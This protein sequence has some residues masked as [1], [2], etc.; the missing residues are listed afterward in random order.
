MFNFPRW[1]NWARSRTVRRSGRPASPGAALPG[2]VAE[3][4]ELSHTTERDFLAVGAR[5]LEFLQCARRIASEMTEMAG[6]IS[7]EEGEH[8]LAA[9]SETLAAAQAMDRRAVEDGGGLASVRDTG[10]RVARAMA[11]LGAVLPAFQAVGTLTRIETA[12]LGNL[13]VDMDGV[14][15]EVEA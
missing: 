1:M 12:R 14:A 7:G 13:G 8:I 3:L 5:L 4:E 9:F 2:L 15:D 11:S 6:R 10:G